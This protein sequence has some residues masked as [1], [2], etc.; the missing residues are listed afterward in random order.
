MKKMCIVCNCEFE[1]RASDYCSSNCSVEM[2]E[3]IISKKESEFK[4]HNK[5]VT[6]RVHQ[7]SAIQ[8]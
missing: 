2:I 6:K 4:P 5:D 8:N 7:P 1:N 3:S